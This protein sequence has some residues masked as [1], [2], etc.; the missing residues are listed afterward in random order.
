MESQAPEVLLSS[1][2]AFGAVRDP[3]IERRKLHPLTNVLV[4]ALGGALAGVT[5]WDEMAFFAKSRLKLFEE[6]LS[7]PHGAPSAD[8]FRRVFEMI[9]PRELEAA[10]RHWVAS[11]SKSFQGEVIAIDGKS[12]RGA[13]ESAGSTTPLHML[14]VYATRQGLLL[15][16]QRVEGAPGEIAAIPEVLKRMRIEGAIVTTDANNCT[17]AVAA[18]IR[19]ADAEYVLALKGNRRHLHGDVADRF[20]KAEQ[21]GFRGTRVHRSSDNGHGREE[22][23]VVRTMTW[24]Q[25]PTQWLDLQSLVMVERT[26]TIADE[27]TTERHYYITSMPPDPEKLG[28]AIRDHWRIENNLHWVLDVA[29]DE[30]SRTIR[31]ETSAENFT[32]MARLALMMLKRSPAKLSI[33]LK[34]KSAQW[35][36]DYL[37]ELLVNGIPSD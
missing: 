6:F 18:A 19:E 22:H 3:R 24:Q 28:R 20:E 17:Q 26:R 21:R 37:R 9:D 36:V 10:L 35:D 23:R 29:F 25:A 7:V 13:I 4:M 2:E 11:V 30:D 32:V 33:N 14:H 31:N 27:S 34:R 1:L 12:L 15:G 8:T 16:Q 5:G